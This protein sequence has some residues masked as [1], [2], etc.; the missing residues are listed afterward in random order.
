MRDD[1]NGSIPNDGHMFD[2]LSTKLLRHSSLIMSMTSTWNII[3]LFLN[4]LRLWSLVFESF[5]KKVEKKCND[6]YSPDIVFRSKVGHLCP[7]C[8]GNCSASLRR[9]LRL[10]APSWLRI[11]GSISVNCLVSAW[12]VMAKVLADR[13]AWTLGLLKWITVPSSLI[14]FTWRGQ[15]HSSSSFF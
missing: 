9:L 10:S 1:R 2:I 6:F 3:V 8:R 13:E 11:P 4:V 15:N 7:P 12:P 5:G 14:M